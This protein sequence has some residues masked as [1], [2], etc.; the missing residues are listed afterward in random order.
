MRSAPSTRSTRGPSNGCFSPDG[1][2]VAYLA[3]K[4]IVVGPVDGNRPL[5]AFPHSA[6]NDVRAVFWPRPDRVAA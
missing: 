5:R 1:S 3:G 4:E 6:P 2:Q